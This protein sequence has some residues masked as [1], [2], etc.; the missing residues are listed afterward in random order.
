MLRNLNHF[1][2]D[3]QIHKTSTRS[4]S[5]SE[6]V[7][8][9]NTGRLLRRAGLIVER[10]WRF[11]WKN[12]IARFGPFTRCQEMTMDGDVVV[13]GRKARHVKADMRRFS[14]DYRNDEPGLLLRIFTA[15]IAVPLALLALLV[16][17][18]TLPLYV[19]V[20]MVLFVLVASVLI[21][22]AFVSFAANI[23][24]TAIGTFQKVRDAYARQR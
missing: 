20:W 14:S 12:G 4:W 1:T 2:L 18:I 22:W 6:T 23:V 5:Q 19:A 8:D 17:L 21:L 3:L 16:T 15:I 13:T 10:G 24:L 7:T 11:E 9:S